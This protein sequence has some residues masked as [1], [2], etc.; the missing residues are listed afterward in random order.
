MDD[1]LLR[2]LGH[3]F[4]Q[5]LLAIG[6]IYV[7]LAELQRVVVIENGWLTLEDFTSLFALAQASPG[8]NT[9]FISLIGWR[10]AGVPGGILATLVFVLPSLVM[11]GILARG[12][13][14]WSDRRWFTVLRRGLVPVTI[15]LLVSSALLLT[16]AAAVSPAALLV[17]GG[18]AGLS[19]GTRL[20][21][22][23]ILGLAGV[24]GAFGLV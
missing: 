24:F 7:I 13:S 1:T 12:W 18:A 6:G 21:P 19:L 5:S 22:V 9:L 20:P 2:L 11:S 4:V 8:P 23:A 3:L 10:V 16:S 14:R 17:T 15:G